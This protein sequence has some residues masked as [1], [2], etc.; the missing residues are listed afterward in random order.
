MF[1]K[2]LFD[3][4]D[5]LTT[6]IMLPLGGLMIALFCGWVAHREMAFEELAM[7]SRFGFQLWWLLIRFVAPVGIVLVFLNAIGVI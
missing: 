3:V 4:K 1:G 6:N 2:T 5:Y 7:R